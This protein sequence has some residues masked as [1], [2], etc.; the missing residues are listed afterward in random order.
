MKIE[1]PG[2]VNNDVVTNYSCDHTGKRANLNVI[3][4]L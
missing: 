2:S 1:H 4:A 3:N